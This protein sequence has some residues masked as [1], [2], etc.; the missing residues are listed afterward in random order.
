MNWK[1]FIETME[2]NGVTEDTEI[3]YIDFAS[4]ESNSI[5]ISFTDEGRAMVDGIEG[6]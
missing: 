6:F 3:A 4:H 1:Q 2:A 5:T